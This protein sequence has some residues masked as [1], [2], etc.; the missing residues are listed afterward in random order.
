MGWG[1]TVWCLAAWVYDAATTACDGL[2]WLGSCRGF[3]FDS[4]G[5]IAS[6]KW[7]R[8]P[9]SMCLFC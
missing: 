7:H 1:V 3:V 4:M 5:S 2:P 6:G 8:T 9:P